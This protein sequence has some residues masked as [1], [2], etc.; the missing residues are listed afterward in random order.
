MPHNRTISASYLEYSEEEELP[1]DI[2]ELIE[3][4]KKASEGAYAPYSGFSVG[5]AVRLSSGKI[6]SGSN[7]ENAAYPSGS[8]AERTALSYAITNHRNDFPVSIAISAR[9]NSG[10]PAQVV[11]P[12]GNCRQFISEEENRTGGRIRII[13]ACKDKTLVFESISDLLPLQ[14]S[15]LSFV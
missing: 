12:C 14:F 11:S 9:G 13:L 6:V 1:R 3:A 5:A 10:I 4:A 8:C 2:G 15:K 7:V